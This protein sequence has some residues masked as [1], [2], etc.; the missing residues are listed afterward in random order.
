MIGENGASCVFLVLFGPQG[1]AL[2]L[3]S[4]TRMALRFSQTVGTFRESENVFTLS[5]FIY[6]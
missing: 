4:I 6:L 5:E 2:A 1:G 3:T